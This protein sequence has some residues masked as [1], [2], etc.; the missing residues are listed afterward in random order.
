[1]I[2]NVIFDFGNVIGKCNI[3]EIAS[4]YTNQCVLVSFQVKT[5][6]GFISILISPSDVLPTLGAFKQISL[7]GIERILLSYAGLF[8]SGLIKHLNSF[9]SDN[10]AVAA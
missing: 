10:M 8:L 9:P 6:P 5:S 1:M 3:E 7:Y 4:K 2:K